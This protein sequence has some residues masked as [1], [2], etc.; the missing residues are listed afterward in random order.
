ALFFTLRTLPMIMDIARDMEE[1]CP[2]AFFLNFS[3]P[4]SRIILALGRYTKLRAVGLCHGIFMGHND[5]ARILGRPYEEIDV[6]GAGLN[7]FQWLLDVRDTK[8]GADLYPELRER[9]KTYDPSFEPFARKLFRAFGRYPSCSDDHIGEYLPYGYEAGEHGYDF[10]A[11][12]RNRATTIAE[13]EDR[14]AGHSSFEDWL[15]VSGERAV[16]IITAIIHNRH[17][18]IESGIVYNRG[19]IP[20]L[21]DDAAVEVPIYADASGIMPM[22][23]GDLSAPI[24]RILTPQVGVQ[25][26][27]VE[28]AVHADKEMA[29]QALLIDPVMNSMDAAAKILDELWEINKPYIRKCV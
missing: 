3:N 17:K 8:S 19:A 29:L 21:P 26:M 1:L 23:V 2:E 24:A 12:D 16:E 25:Q 4:E 22:R 13:I 10:E 15:H 27:A 20:N 6:R 5:V 18:P 14:L 9:D 7:H 28:A 11:D